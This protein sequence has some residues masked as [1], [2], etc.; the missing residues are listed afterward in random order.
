MN[1]Y[2]NRIEQLVEQRLSAGSATKKPAKGLLGPKKPMQ[3]K[4]PFSSRKQNMMMERI[5]D[6]VL[7]IRKMRMEIKQ[8][9]N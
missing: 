8:N 5:A 1:R 6:Y 7:D 4:G 2:I 9:G 3:S